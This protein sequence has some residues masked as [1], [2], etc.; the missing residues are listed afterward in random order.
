MRVQSFIT[1][2]SNNPDIHTVKKKN[3][4]YKKKNPS[5][6]PNVIFHLNVTYYKDAALL[7]QQEQSSS[8]IIN[9]GKSTIRTAH[10]L[11]KTLPPPPKKKGVKTH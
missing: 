6:T 8:F 3:L 2:Y 7:V 5:A 11:Y 4:N 9:P 1:F 10:M